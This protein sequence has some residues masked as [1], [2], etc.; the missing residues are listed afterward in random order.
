MHLAWQLIWTRDS[1]KPGIDSNKEKKKKKKKNRQSSPRPLV[2][3][4]VRENQTKWLSLGSGLTLSLP[5]NVEKCVTDVVRIGSVI[6]FHLSKLW[7]AKF[8][9]LFDVILLVRLQE[10]SEIDSSWEW[11]VF[12]C[13]AQ[14]LLL[15]F[16]LPQLL[17]SAIKSLLLNFRQDQSYGKYSDQIIVKKLS[18]WSRHPYSYV[19]LSSHEPVPSSQLRMVIRGIMY[20][21]L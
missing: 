4:C 18:R 16:K 14:L 6:I 5:R 15:Q 8:F 12:N 10:K 13:S 9:I 1:A 19:V 7:R 20:L 11:K 2:C 17:S 3:V 21:F